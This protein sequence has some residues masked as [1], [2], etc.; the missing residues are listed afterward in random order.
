MKSASLSEA[1]FTCLDSRRQGDDPFVNYRCGLTLFGFKQ[2]HK[3]LGKRKP[4]PPC[5]SMGRAGAGAA[6]RWSKG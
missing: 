6:N 2:T 5:Q 4:E 1:L 3:E